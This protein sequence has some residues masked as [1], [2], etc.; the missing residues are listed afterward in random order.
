MQKQKS[1]YF[2]SRGQLCYADIAGIH[3]VATCFLA[4]GYTFI[5]AGNN[6][7]FFQG[8]AKECP[9]LILLCSSALK[10]YFKD[11]RYG[12]DFWHMGMHP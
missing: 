6:E 5:G 12:D 8:Y 10:W 2:N 9:K 4:Y 7:A 3:W 1:I 11:W